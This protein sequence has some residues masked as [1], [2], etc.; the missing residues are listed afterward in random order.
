MAKKYIDPDI[1]DGW[2]IELSRTTDRGHEII[3]TTAKELAN[4][5][6]AADVVEVV[7]CKDCGLR[8]E[9]TVMWKPC[10]DV[11]VKDNWF[12]GYGEKR[13]E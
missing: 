4:V 3:T 1:L 6:P 10:D 8:D 12:C 11:L 2:E 5:L 13:N 9:I 7:R